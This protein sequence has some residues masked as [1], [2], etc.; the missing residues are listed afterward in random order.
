MLNKKELQ[1]EMAKDKKPWEESGDLRK[2]AIKIFETETFPIVSPDRMKFFITTNVKE[3]L[4]KKYKVMLVKDLLQVYMPEVNYV[5]AIDRAYWNELD[6]ADQIYVMAHCLLHCSVNENGAPVLVQ[7][8]V[9][10][11]KELMVE[12]YID[13]KKITSIPVGE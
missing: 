8:D 10:E 4:N 12:D 9:K 13:L 7:P 5:V 6:D 3:L 2:L 1:D 11:Y